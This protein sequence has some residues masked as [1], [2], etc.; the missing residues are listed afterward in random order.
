ML[1]A[2]KLSGIAL[3]KSARILVSLVMF[4]NVPMVIKISEISA[5]HTVTA[6]VTNND[7]SNFFFW[8]SAAIE[9]RQISGCGN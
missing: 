9:D 4:M 6:E 1:A 2:L 7:F 3:Y 5:V 8:I